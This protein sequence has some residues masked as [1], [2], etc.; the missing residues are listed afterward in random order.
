MRTVILPV[1]S[2]ELSTQMAAMRVWLDERRFE[3]SSFSCRD[4]GTAVVVRVD[5][6]V[7]DEATAFAR[8]FSG[9]VDEVLARVAGAP[10]RIGLFSG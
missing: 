6:K 5:F 8:H 9:Q 7:A 1:K 4:S 3:P 2:S 10:E